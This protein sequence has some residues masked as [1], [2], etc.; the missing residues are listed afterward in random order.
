MSQFLSPGAEDG[1]PFGDRFAVSATGRRFTS[2][3]KGGSL[4]MLALWVEEVIS[5]IA[6]S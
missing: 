5:H 6:S 3:R 1:E 4:P 2:E